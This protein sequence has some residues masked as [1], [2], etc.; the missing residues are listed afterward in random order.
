MLRNIPD[1]ISPDLM[2]I[3][4]EMGHGDEICFGDA[5]FPA[6]SIGNRVVRCDGHKVTDLLDAVLQLFPLDVFVKYPAAMMQ[7]VREEDPIP[8]VWDEYRRI[9]QKNDF[10]KAFTEFEM[11][12]RFAFYVRAKKS[13]AVVATSEHEPYACVILTKGIILK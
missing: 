6:Q 3:L 8:K 12:E 7:R 4:M 9:I 5:N 11:L 10:S 1:I 2:K 13:Y